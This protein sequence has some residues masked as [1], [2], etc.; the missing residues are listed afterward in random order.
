MTKDAW[1]ETAIERAR[2]L[3]QV[4]LR[5]LT[6]VNRDIAKL[7]QIINGERKKA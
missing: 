4:K 7:R 1:A 5:L 6:K 2:R 3:L